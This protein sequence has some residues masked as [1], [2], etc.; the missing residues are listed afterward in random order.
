MGEQCLLAFLRLMFSYLSYT[1]HASLPAGNATHCRL[2]LPTSNS[3]QEAPSPQICNNQGR[4]HNHPALLSQAFHC[5]LDI[6]HTGWPFRGRM[7]EGTEQQPIFLTSSLV[8]TQRWFH[9][10]CIKSISIHHC[11]PT[12]KTDTSVTIVF[13]NCGPWIRDCKDF[14]L[15]RIKLQ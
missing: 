9:S 3:N 12:F 11:S 8:F 5:V 14:N 4:H 6:L 2:S 1:Y 10:P 7:E 13:N 15:T